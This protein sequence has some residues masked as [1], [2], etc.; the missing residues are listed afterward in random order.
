LRNPCDLLVG[1]K[2]YGHRLVGTEL[3]KKNAMNEFNI[4]DC[5]YKELTIHWVANEEMQQSQPNES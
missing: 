4:K 1:I 3:K 2:E 5:C